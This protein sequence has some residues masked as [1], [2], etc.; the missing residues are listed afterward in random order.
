MGTTNCQDQPNYQLRCNGAASFEQ[1]VVDVLVTK[2][3]RAVQEF[4]AKSVILC[5]GVAANKALRANLRRT[6][7]DL[8]L[9]F[10]VPPNDL[11]GDNAAMIAMSTYINHLK[12]KKYPLIT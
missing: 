1:A 4:G 9:N 12:K 3:M 10:F 5:G 2:T 7:N 8:R 6:T 11:N